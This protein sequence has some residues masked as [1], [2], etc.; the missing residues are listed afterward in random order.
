MV[1]LK[2]AYSRPMSTT[3]GSAAMALEELTPLSVRL[4]AGTEQYYSRT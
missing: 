2:K 4:R 1:E 3:L